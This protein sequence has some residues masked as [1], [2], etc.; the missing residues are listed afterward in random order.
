VYGS[1]SPTKTTIALPSKLADEWFITRLLPCF[2][3]SNFF[4]SHKSIV[5]ILILEVTGIPE[6]SAN[7]G[8]PW[9]KP[10]F[11]ESTTGFVFEVSKYRFRFFLEI[12]ID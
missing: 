12:P 10:H 6:L 7:R 8:F 9:P 2:P 5:A 3:C 4:C 11:I 1:D